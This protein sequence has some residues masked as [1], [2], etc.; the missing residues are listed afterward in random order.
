[1]L[2]TTKDFIGHCRGVDTDIGHAEP[3]QYNIDSVLALHWFVCVWISEIEE[4]P[5]SV[6]KQLFDELLDANA[7]KGYNLAKCY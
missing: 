6:K 7:Q 1:M 4:L 2:L 3:Q 5:H